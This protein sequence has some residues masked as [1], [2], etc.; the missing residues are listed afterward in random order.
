MVAPVIPS[1]SPPPLGL[2]VSPFSTSERFHSPF[3]LRAYW[4]ARHIVFALF[5][6]PGSIPLPAGVPS[7]PAPWA[8][9]PGIGHLTPP[10]PL[11]LPSP[12][13]LLSQGEYSV[14]PAPSGVMLQSLVWCNSC[15]RQVHACRK[16]PD[17]GGER[18]GAGR[19]GGGARGAEPEESLN[20]ERAEP[21]A[22]RQEKAG[23]RPSGRELK[24]TE[25]GRSIAP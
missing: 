22:G 11:A 9:L 4:R 2:D 5:T 23:R 7:T 10:Q 25:L 3:L 12:F 14:D 16:H 8:D 13:S 6:E 15:E 18:A 1:R 17:C 21:G 19:S 20:L 24:G